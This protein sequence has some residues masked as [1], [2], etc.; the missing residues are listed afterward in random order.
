MSDSFENIQFK[1]GDGA[2]IWVGS[3]R[4][5]ATVVEVSKTGHR[6]VVQRDYAIAAPASV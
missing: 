1:V 2:T 4:Y 3:D 6:V 5:A